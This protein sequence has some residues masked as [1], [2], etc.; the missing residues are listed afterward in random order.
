MTKM[1]KNRQKALFAKT[2]QNKTFY[3]VPPTK[4][5]GQ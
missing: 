4:M 3:R 2:P 1:T 5:M